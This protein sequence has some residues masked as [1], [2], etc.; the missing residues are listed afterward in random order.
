MGD[1]KMDLIGK[2]AVF[3][4]CR[5]EEIAWIARVADTIDL[6]AGRTLAIEG[7]TAR[8]FLLLVRGTVTASNGTG[9]VTLSPGAQLGAAELVRGGR[10]TRHVQTSTPVKLL[11]FGAPAFRGMLDRIPAVG[12]RLLQEI[13]TEIH[14]KDQTSRS[15]RAVS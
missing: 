1:L 4:G 14:P 6:P 10:H 15:L 2:L 7:E 12:R 3:Q 5:R 11:V 8:E 13:V 9:D